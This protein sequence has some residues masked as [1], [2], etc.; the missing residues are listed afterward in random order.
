M[1]GA[2]KRSQ[3][4]R[5]MDENTDVTERA[6]SPF[7][8]LLKQNKGLRLGPKASLEIPL[9]FAPEDMRM[10]EATVSVSVTKLDRSSWPYICTDENGCVLPYCVYI[11]VHTHVHCSY[12]NEWLSYVPVFII[13][14]VTR[15][16]NTAS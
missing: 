5:V 13:S 15:C 1:C 4:S 6:V 10:F 14:S 11:H 16:L 2:E 3:L 9:S 8:L 12:M 7:C